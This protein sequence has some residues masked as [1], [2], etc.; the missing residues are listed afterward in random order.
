MSNKLQDEVKKQ[1]EAEK[2]EKQ[3][4]QIR[5]RLYKVENIDR[6]IDELEMEKEKLEEEIEKIEEEPL[7]EQYPAQKYINITWTTRRFPFNDFREVN[8]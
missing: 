8:C 3:L 5:E 6:K 7:D 4:R 1:L 2:K